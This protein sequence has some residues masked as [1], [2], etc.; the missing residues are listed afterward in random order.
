[1]TLVESEKSGELLSVKASVVECVSVP[2]VAVTI[3]VEFPKG[4]LP[5]VVTVTVALPDV[6]I[7]C[8]L[9]AAPTPGGSPEILKFT[10][11]ENAP[12]GVTERT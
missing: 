4:A 12:S 11:P 2:L 8:G 1:M 5:D 6:V 10:G 3:G 9:N 7:D